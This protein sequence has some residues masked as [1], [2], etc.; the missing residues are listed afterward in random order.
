MIL[1]G[2]L[3][4]FIIILDGCCEVNEVV[5]Q[6]VKVLVENLVGE[7]GCGWIYVKVL[8]IYEC[9]NIVG[10]VVFKQCL[11]VL[12]DLLNQLLVGCLDLKNNSV[13]MSCVVQVEM[14]FKVLEFIDL[15]VLLLV[16]IGIVLGLE[17]FILKIKG[18]EI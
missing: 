5:F 12:Y 1:L 10:V 3:V 14:E 11:S 13:F 16:S 2:V 18:I 9:I 7:E 4:K 15:C 8:L 6:D 17:L